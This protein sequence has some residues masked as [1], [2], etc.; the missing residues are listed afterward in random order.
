MWKLYQSAWIEVK[1]NIPEQ[2][3][4]LSSFPPSNP[5]PHYFLNIMHLFLDTMHPRSASA[6]IDTKY[7]RKRAITHS[8]ISQ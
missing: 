2:T 1:I 4:P 7:S 5:H 8:H 6:G 3:V